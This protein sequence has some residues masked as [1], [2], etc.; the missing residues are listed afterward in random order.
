MRLISLAALPVCLFATAVLADPPT[1][2]P[3]DGI[4]AEAIDR[5]VDPCTDFYHF[6]CN[7]WL[8]ANPVPPDRSVWDVGGPLD[9]RIQATLRGILEHA[10]SGN[11]PDTKKLGDYWAACMDEAAIA[12]RG[13]DA[14]K[15]E[16]DRIDA[17]TAK[18]DLAPLIARLHRA[19]VDAFF[20]FGS[21]QD[22]A[23]ATQVIAE[24]DQGGLGLPDR[25]YYTKTDKDSQHTRDRYHDHLVKSARLA[26]LANPETV[27]ATVVQLET[28]LAQASLT[29][30]QRIDPHA[31]YHKMTLKA[32]DALA[33]DFAWPDYL[34][35]VGA[36]ETIDSLNVAVPGFFQ[37]LAAV[38]DATPLD[39]IKT[40]LKVRLIEEASG[41]LP[42]AFVDESFDFYGRTLRGAK[43]LRPRWKRCVSGAD[44][45]LG[46][47]LGR[48]YVRD[49]FPPEAKARVKSMVGEIKAAFA[50]DLKTIPW[51]GAET[52]EKAVAK[53]AAMVEKIGYPDKWRDYAKLEI[54]R[55]D[56]LGNRF[57]AAAFELDRQLAKIG[58]PVDR[59]EWGMTP[60]TVNAYYDP[61]KND[62]NFPAGI[63]QVPYFNLSWDDAVN[64]GSIGAVIGHEMTHGFDNQGRMFDLAG[65]L[66]DW[67]TKQD[68]AG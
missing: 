41:L 19:G 36:P 7:G 37:S 28:R 47:E 27:A 44:S 25:D 9:E 54:R 1:T 26:G 14:L 38:I 42:Q 32:F 66:K 6:A 18:P 29:R 13:L 20:A 67:W 30:E 33:K 31:T 2:K 24:A 64:Y 34:K 50:E 43:Q 45:D 39:D 68:A 65:N 63:L 3:A 60:P 35:T 61:Q 59:G 40:Y 56:A 46:E 21:D 10:A 55:D 51:M 58:K 52:R 49:V 23:D 57:R 48:I 16:L 5:S 12:K 8:K 53:L 22:A 62:I 4:M 11:D 17:V 15:P